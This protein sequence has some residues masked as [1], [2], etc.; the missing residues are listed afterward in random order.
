[1]ESGSL[2]F[3]NPYVQHIMCLRHILQH[4]MWLQQRL[5]VKNRLQ[6]E[7]AETNRLQQDAAGETQFCSLGGIMLGLSNPPASRSL[8]RV[9]A[10]RGA[11]CEGESGCCVS[12]L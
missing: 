2:Q 7:I 8:R 6:Q 4:N 9:A 11:D 12:V 1:M 5:Q 3:V 10:L